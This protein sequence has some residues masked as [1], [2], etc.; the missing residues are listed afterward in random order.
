MKEASSRQSPHRLPHLLQPRCP[1][2]GR[3]ENHGSKILADEI[4]DADGAENDV[5]PEVFQRVAEDVDLDFLRRVAG[6]EDGG[7]AAGE[8]F[9][10]AVFGEGVAEALPQDAVDPAFEDGRGHSP[11]VG[12]D[13]DVQVGVEHLLDVVE[14]RPG[15][16]LHRQGHFVH[17]QDGIEALGVQVADGDFV[18]G[19]LERFAGG[20]EDGPAE[21]G[22]GV[23]VCENE[24]GFHFWFVVGVSCV[25]KGVAYNYTVCGVKVKPVI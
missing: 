7:F 10:D 12:V 18:A 20:G 4:V 15:D 19:G 2:L 21:A 8:F 5:P 1:L 6:G 11:P 23:L 22:A 16:L 24:E 17:L 14:Q 3:A 9:H 13:D 25:S